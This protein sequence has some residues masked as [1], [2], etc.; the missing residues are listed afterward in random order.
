MRRGSLTIEHLGKLLP[1]VAKRWNASRDH[2][3]L[4]GSLR[5]V[6]TSEEEVTYAHDGFLTNSSWTR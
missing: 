3:D 4:A 6:V 5:K 2:L 1:T